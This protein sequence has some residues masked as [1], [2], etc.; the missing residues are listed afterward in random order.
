MRTWSEGA[1]AQPDLSLHWAHRSFCWF[2]HAAALSHILEF[3]KP[4]VYEVYRGYIV[5]VF[6]VT[7]FVCGGGGGGRGPGLCVNI[8]FRQRFLRNY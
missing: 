3:I 2:C 4:S 8:F 5:F 1:S 7:M 6:S